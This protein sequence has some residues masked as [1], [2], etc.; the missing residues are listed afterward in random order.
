MSPLS[1]G[2]AKRR[3]KG[4]E[5]R[6]QRGGL[7]HIIGCTRGV[8][9]SNMYKDLTLN[10]KFLIRQ[11]FSKLSSMSTAPKV[12]LVCVSQG[13]MLEVRSML[14]LDFKYVPSVFLIN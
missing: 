2:W 11:N 10:L 12:L 13:E 3:A 4:G 7:S 1:E 9:G 5:N 8:H 6:Q 14:L